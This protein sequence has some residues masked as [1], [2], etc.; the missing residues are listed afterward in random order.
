MQERHHKETVVARR[1]ALNVDR[2]EIYIA[3]YEKVSGGS[4][5]TQRRTGLSR[6]T[7]K[8]S[9]SFICF[10]CPKAKLLFKIYQVRIQ[11][12]V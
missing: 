6:L 11:Q 5:F 9:R 4:C 8:G 3:V 1:I 10:R 7:S 2:N 12:R